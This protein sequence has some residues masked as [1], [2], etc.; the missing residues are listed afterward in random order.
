[1]K[2]KTCKMENEPKYRG[3][4][5]G[6]NGAVWTVEVKIYNPALVYSQSVQKDF[7]TWQLKVILN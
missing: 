1:M 5:T 7:K 4:T 6:E 2:I 3:V